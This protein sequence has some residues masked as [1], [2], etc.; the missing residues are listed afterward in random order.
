MNAHGRAKQHSGQPAHPLLTTLGTMPTGHSGQSLGGTHTGPI[1]AI[2][3]VVETELFI[4]A[5]DKENDFISV[6]FE[7]NF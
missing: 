6:I 2:L 3:D 5:K 1:I 7:L 4:I